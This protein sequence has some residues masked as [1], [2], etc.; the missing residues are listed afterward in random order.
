MYKKISKL[1]FP[2]III[3]IS[4]FI[5]FKNYTPNTYLIGWDSLHPEFNFPEAFRR[6]WEGVWRAEQGVGAIAAHSHMADLPRIVFL[7]LES[8]ILPTS[9]LRYSYIFL[10]LVLGPLGVYFF[11]KYVFQ[12]EKNSFWIYPAAFLGALFYLLNL[13][14]LQNF[15]VPFEMFTAAFAFIPWI[16]FLGLKFIREGSRSNLVFW[17]MVLIISSPMAY[18]ATLWYASFSGLF[19]FLFVYALISSDRLVQIKRF[20]VLVLT[21]VLLNLYW[22]LPNIYSVI[23]QSGV[24]SNS[25]INRLFSS[26]AFLRNRDYG[27]I[28]DILLQKNFLFDWRNFDAN[29]NQFTDLMNVWTKYLSNTLVITVGYILAGFSVI[30]LL[31]G[32]VKRNKTALAFIPALL[33]CLFFL[34]NINPPSGSLYSY[35]YNNFGIFAEGFRMPFTKFS[36]L[37]E[38]IAAFYFG[39]FAFLL[40]TL[41]ESPLKVIIVF[42]KAFKT[43]FLVS[44]VLGLVYFMRPA[45]EGNFIG[46]NVKIKLPSEYLQIFNWF[47][48]NSEG[49]IALFPINS[50]YGWEYRNWDLPAGRQGYEGSGFLTYGISNPI[51]Y[52]DFDRWSTGN[53]DFY[54]QSSFAL[55][56][57]DSQGFINTLKKYQVKYLLLD[58]SIINPGGT[59]DIL[60]IPELKKIFTESGFREV[61]KSGFLVVYETDYGSGITSPPKFTQITSDSSYSPIDPNF[62]TLGDYITSGTYT[63][64]RKSPELPKIAPAVSENLSINRGFPEAY[65]CDLKK[66]GRVFKLN[67]SGGILYRAENGGASCDYLPYADLKY[68]QTYVLR[69]AGENRQGRSLKIY[70]FN[71]Y[72]QVPDVEEILPAG[73]FDKTYFV[74]P[75]N[76]TGSG[77]ILNLETR[78]FGRIASENLLSKVEFYPVESNYL[79]TLQGT[80]LQGVQNNLKILDVKKYGSWAYKVKTE[81][82]GLLQLGQGYDGGWVAIQSQNSNLISQIYNSKLKI[83]EHVKVNSWANGWN[84]ES[85]IMNQESR[86][87]I[88]Y[89]PQ[90]LEWGGG[91]SGL[92]TLLFIGLY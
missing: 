54:T 84:L 20:F 12:K 27:T 34:I 73:V 48:S 88:V 46:Q 81:G 11:L 60:K 64:A 79:S 78:S 31:L 18:A 23:N 37:Y 19:I 43:L 62:K 40:L 76:A 67:S 49:R 61:T 86:I 71:E 25:N 89:W 59:S 75:K 29:T 82:A 83:L 24:I 53:E 9:F 33:F 92:L 26:E 4:A 41:K 10:C 3:L 74:Y 56:S 7:W 5:C 32:T 85:G 15:Y 66:N 57:N 69:V 21:A 2:L 30:G 91:I 22:I 55:Y 14:T 42:V 72:S 8:F 36:I 70:L 50:K 6:V 39:C 90:L 77:Y 17:V 52:R 1:V 80:T 58:E 35:L 45:F 47:S 13:G 51:L 63:P 87:W 44:V 65:N 16:V 28:T 38:L 68:G